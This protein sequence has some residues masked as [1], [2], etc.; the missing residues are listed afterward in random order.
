MS[1][2]EQKKPRVDQETA[3]GRLDQSA[4]ADEDDFDEEEESLR[5]AHELA[6][7]AMES[8]SY[9]ERIKLARRSLEFNTDCADAWL[10]LAD[11]LTLSPPEVELYLLRALSS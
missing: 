10:L 8:S 7:D 6:Y 3:T 2:K 11:H 5:L 9:K 4:P 1:G